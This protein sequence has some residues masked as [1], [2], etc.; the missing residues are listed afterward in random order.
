M[1]LNPPAAT[2]DLPERP[3]FFGHMGL[4]GDFVACHLAQG[5]PM[6][7]SGIARPSYGLITHT[8]GPLEPH[9]AHTTL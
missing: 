7:G 8:R 4:H 6:S 1:I 2:E 9:T 5:F 3:L